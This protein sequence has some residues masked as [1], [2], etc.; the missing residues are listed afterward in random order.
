MLPPH[1]SSKVFLAPMAGITDQPL[2][3]LTRSFGSCNIVSEM[4]AVN[5]VSR[6]NPKTYRIADVRAEN[7]PVTVQLVGNE[8]ELFVQVVPLIEELG[9]AGIDINM[10]CPVKKIVN[11]RSGSYLMTDIARAASIITQVRNTTRLPLSIKFRKGWDCN[12]INA[13]EFAKMCEDCGADYLTLHGRTKTEM[14]SG[15]ADW[16]IIGEVKAAIKIPL[17]GNGDIT[18]PQTARQMLDYTQADGVMIGRAALGRPWLI[19]QTH[20]FLEHGILSQPMSIELI[21]TTMLRHIR[22]LS[23]YYGEKTALQLARKY[24]C[25]YCK[26]MRDACRFREKFVRIADMSQALVEID[27][28][29]DY[30]REEALS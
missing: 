19:A 24:V 20:K 8:P 15:T 4:V 29:F 9:A 22:A 7:Y 3:Q 6:R 21:K 18:S 16:D 12:H 27:R 13:V 2:R 23:D 5:A 25:W 26:G 17:I 30:N 14:Y 1:L 28:F 10:G 11:N